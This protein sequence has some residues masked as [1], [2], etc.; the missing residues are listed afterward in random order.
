MYGK[1]LSQVGSYVT[2]AATSCTAAA[3]DMMTQ[4]QYVQI[5]AAT[6][7]LLL[8]KMVLTFH[9]GVLSRTYIEI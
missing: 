9:T 1:F 8:P 6:I 5:A 3:V 4:T 2:K 7:L